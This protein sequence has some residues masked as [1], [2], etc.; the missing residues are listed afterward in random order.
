MSGWEGNMIL[1]PV[2]PY[3]LLAM[4]FFSCGFLSSE[5]LTFSN[6]AL[7]VGLCEYLHQAAKTSWFKEP[8]RLVLL[9]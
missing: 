7:C 2:D 8:V 4:C 1:G 3:R 5:L 9:P 6:W